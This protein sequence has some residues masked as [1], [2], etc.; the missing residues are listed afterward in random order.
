MQKH[1]LKFSN[2]SQ[3]IIYAILAC[4]FG[5][6]LVNLVRFLADGFDVFFIIMMRNFFGF[7]FLLPKILQ[8]YRQVLH[9][10]K[11]HFHFFRAFIGFVSMSFWFYALISMPLSEAVSLS[12]IAPI[13]TTAAAVVFLKEKVKSHIWVATIVG[14]IGILII[15][16]PGFKTFNPAYFYSFAAVITW[17]GSNLIIKVMTK[18]ESSRTIVTYMSFL[19]FIASTPL[20]ITHIKFVSGYDLILFILLGLISNLLYFCISNSYSK[21]NLSYVQPVD[22][23]RLIFT[24]IM[25]YFIFGEILDIWVLL[26]SLVILCGVIISLPKKKIKRSKI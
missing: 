6:I 7:L 26:G 24:S 4:F 8:D 23:T 22:F 17:V 11:I 9:T 10:K 16:R 1:L 15:L 20:A 14:F 2:N 3:G 25:A 21:A 12:F 13:L 5:S 18:T 19:L